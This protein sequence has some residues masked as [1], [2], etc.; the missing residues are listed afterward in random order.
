MNQDEHK[1][2]T[3]VAAL[4]FSHREAMES[5]LF[6]QLQTPNIDD[7]RQSA[8]AAAVYF[9]TTIEG[10]VG[11]DPETYISLERLGVVGLAV[12]GTGA[13][14]GAVG[15]SVGSRVRR[16]PPPPRRVSR[17]CWM[18]SLTAVE[19]RIKE[20]RMINFMICVV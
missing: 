7:R 15:A 18:S 14:A 19:V 5:S 11:C 1:S 17:S 16:R 9:S 13:G 3:L 2:L 4:V 10:V 12:L 20:E 6:L 8:I